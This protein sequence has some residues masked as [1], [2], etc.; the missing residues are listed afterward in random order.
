MTFESK[1]FVNAAGFDSLR[2]AQQAGL[3]QNYTLLPLKGRYAISEQ[4]VSDRYKMIIYPVPVKGAMNLGVHST[5]TLDGRIKYGPTVFP[6]FSPTNY[7][8]L[9]NVTPYDVA[10]TLHTFSYVLRSPTDRKLVGQ[11]LTTELHKSLSISS[12]L[13]EGSR[14]QSYDKDLT[15]K[16]YRAGIRPFLFDTENLKL[17]TD[18]KIET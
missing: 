4:D 12:L 8:Y 7:D 5:L 13:K 17:V 3:A 6:A 2:V 10:K 11:Y 16:F 9:E 18:W 15:W 1:L 14:V